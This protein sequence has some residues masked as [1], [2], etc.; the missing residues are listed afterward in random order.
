MWQ[1][2]TPYRICKF[3]GLVL[4]KALFFTFPYMFLIMLIILGV[5]GWKVPEV[6][7]RSWCHNCH[8]RLSW[9][10]SLDTRHVWHVARSRVCGCV[11]TWQGVWYCTGKIF[12]VKKYWI[13]SGKR[14][15]NH[16]SYFNT[17]SWEANKNNFLFQFY[18]SLLRSCFPCV[19]DHVAW[20]LVH[21]VTLPPRASNINVNSVNSGNTGAWSLSCADHK[22][23]LSQLVK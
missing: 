2:I 23:V 10:A 16:F 13:R 14:C 17:R 8:S 1:H 7:T 11:C 21:P 19:R 4:F 22:T 18:I 9:E 12:A 3:S 15:Q 5:G 20:T 6:V